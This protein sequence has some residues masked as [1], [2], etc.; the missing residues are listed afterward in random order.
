MSD[1]LRADIATLLERLLLADMP[2]STARH[3]VRP[4]VLVEMETFHARLLACDQYVDD[5]DSDDLPDWIRRFREGII[6][7]EKFLLYVDLVAVERTRVQAIPVYAACFDVIWRRRMMHM[8][9][10]GD[11]FAGSDVDLETAKARAH[12]LEQCERNA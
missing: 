3:A 2:G 5:T 12:V 11:Q 8:K 4:I 6:D 7:M 1:Q 10:R 9:H